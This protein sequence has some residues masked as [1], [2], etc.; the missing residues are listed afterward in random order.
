MN[1]LK[2][3]LATAIMAV[4]IQASAQIAQMVYLP[5]FPVKKA[6]TETVQT[7]PTPA[8]DEKAA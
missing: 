3:A 4:S 2:F 7:E 1:M 6:E 5:D 8:E